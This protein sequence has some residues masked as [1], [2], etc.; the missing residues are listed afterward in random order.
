ML[1]KWKSKTTDLVVNVLKIEGESVW[2]EHPAW[3]TLQNCTK[4]V[5][6]ES[7]E[8]VRECPTKSPTFIQFRR[9][10]VNFGMFGL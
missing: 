10:E 2:Y 1:G 4:G 6:L 7:M 8:R 3:S 9:D 5:F